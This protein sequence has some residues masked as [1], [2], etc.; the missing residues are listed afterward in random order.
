MLVNPNPVAATAERINWRTD[1]ALQWYIGQGH[2]VLSK[3]ALGAQLDRIRD[4]VAFS[5]VYTY[6]TPDWLLD[7]NRSSIVHRARVTAISLWGAAMLYGPAV[8]V[9]WAYCNPTTVTACDGLYGNVGRLLA[10]LPL[11]PTGATAMRPDG[12]YIVHKRGMR[13]F[14]ALRQLNADRC[15]AK[16]DERKVW[17]QMVKEARYARDRS[18]DAYERA[19]RFVDNFEREFRMPPNRA[20]LAEGL[21]VTL[22]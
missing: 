18:F 20:E 1:E 22:W 12:H 13:P 3:S 19:R 9:I 21:G 17:A 10:V 11:T 5:G 8:S 15:Q 16:G 7:F 2:D 4:E 6:D 14:D